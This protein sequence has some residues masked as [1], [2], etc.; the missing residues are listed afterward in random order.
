MKSFG[1]GMIVFPH[2]IHVDR[3]GNV[4]VTDGKD[5]S[6]RRAA[7]GAAMP[8]R[9]TPPPPAAKPV[10]HQVFKFSPEGKLLMTLGKA[11]V[12]G[13]PPEALTEPN[14]V[15]TAPNGD[16]FVAEG[17][18]GQ[19]ANAAPDTVARISMFTRTASS[20]VVGQAGIG[21]GEFR[22]PHSLAFDSRGR[23]FVADRGNVRHAD[24]RSGR[25]VSRGDEA[26][27]PPERHLHRQERHAV[28]RRLGVEPT[29]STRHGGAACASAAPRIS[30]PMYLHPGSRR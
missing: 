24:L 27:Q 5:N 9:A 17:H 8:R 23:L 2:G 21:P 6:C 15:I 13:N 22:T 16:I 20:S 28:R 25:E 10:G 7:D 12:R 3:D 1:A 4:W 11:G 29:T 26:V 19:N 14:D 18:G 30:K